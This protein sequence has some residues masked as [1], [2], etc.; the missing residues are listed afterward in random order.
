MGV[1]DLTV[2][3]LS[4]EEARSL[5]DEVKHD[6]ERLWRKLVELYEGDAHT[7]Q[8]KGRYLIARG[9]ADAPD[10]DGRIYVRGK[11]TV[12]EFA[13]VKV[14]GSKLANSATS[15]IEILGRIV[16]AVRTR[17]SLTRTPK[18]RNFCARSRS[19]RAVTKVIQKK[20]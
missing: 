2:A 9:E 20:T 8:L 4:R 15:R 7:A 16:S 19:R 14:V 12:G 17:H 5:T 3:V 11:L 10:I 13:R 18:R 6:A 1:V